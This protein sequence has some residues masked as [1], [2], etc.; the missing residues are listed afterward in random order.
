MT[1]KQL[2]MVGIIHPAYAH[3]GMVPSDEMCMRSGGPVPGQAPVPGDSP[4]ND[5]VHA[6]LSPGEFVVPRSIVQNHPE[7]IASL[8]SA[9][10][11]MRGAK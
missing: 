2:T 1:L 5:T 10:R 4:M 6:R 7:D 9:M 8:L 11:H 3:G